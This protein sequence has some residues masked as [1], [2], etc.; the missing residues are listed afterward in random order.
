MKAINSVILPAMFLSAGDLCGAWPSGQIRRYPRK[1]YEN[2]A[3]I[4]ACAKRRAKN[5]AARKSKQ[6]N[7]NK[8]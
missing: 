1:K 4:K 8:R 2:A 6:R 5:K 7:R 3:N